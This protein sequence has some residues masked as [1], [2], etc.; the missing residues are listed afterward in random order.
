MIKVLVFLADGFEEIEAITPVDYLRRAGC[1][2][3]TAAVTGDCIE[4]KG[5]HG[6]TVRSDTTLK[7]FIEEKAFTDLDAV[8]IP[9]GMPGASN[10][11]CDAE[12][13][14]LI[15]YMEENKKLICAIC[16][17]PAV[18]LGRTDVL[19]DKKWCCYPDMESNAA[20]YVSLY[21]KGVRVVHD[22]NLITGIG[23]G[24]AEEFSLEI[25]RTLS[26]EKEAER[27]ASSS[28]QR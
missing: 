2:V 16:A 27:I 5:A 28:C 4:V 12:A 17:S 18:V 25:V 3:V 6:I 24:G 26:G 23:P 21:Q 20:S 13:L 11:A 1:D 14:D 10:I 15:N 8:V 19:K 7:S 9:G 22:H